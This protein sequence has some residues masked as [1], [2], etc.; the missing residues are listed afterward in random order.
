M[1]PED[2]INACSMAVPTCVQ[3]GGTNVQHWQ[4]NCLRNQKEKETKSRFQRPPLR[5]EVWKVS[6][7]KTEIYHILRMTNGRQKTLWYV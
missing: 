7:S 1:F 3:Y 5:R 6:L 4:R 2:K